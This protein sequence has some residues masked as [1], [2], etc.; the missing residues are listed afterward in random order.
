MKF[1]MTFEVVTEASVVRG[2]FARHG[3]LPKSGNIP[4]KNYFP[5]N[6]HRFKLR[7]AIELLFNRASKGPVETDSS[8]VSLRNPPRWFTYGGCSADY[9]NSIQVSLH[10]P[11]DISPSSAMRVYRLIKNR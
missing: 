5:R 3:F 11:R 8:H 2:D 1:R 4:N 10:L 7:E 9:F 6:P